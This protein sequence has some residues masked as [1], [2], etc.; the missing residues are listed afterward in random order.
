MSLAGKIA[1][2][3]A[4]Y[5]MSYLFMQGI[6][7]VLALFIRHTLG[8]EQMGVWVG[9]Q[10]LLSYSKYSNLGLG[11]A[12]G[13]EIPFEKGRG[14]L[15]RAERIR[16]SSYTFTL[17]SAAVLSV[18]MVAGAV[19][20]RRRYG[21]L[22]FY[23]LLSLA[24]LS[25][26]QRASTFC[27]SLLRAEKQFS[28]I[29][30]FNV[31]SALVNAGLTVG[32][33]MA[34]GLYGYYAA[35]I[36]SFVFNFY[37]VRCFS[38]VKFGL[39]WEWRELGPLFTMGLGLIASN[40][41]FTFFCSVDK[42]SIGS[43]LGF[44]ELGLYSL[45]IMVSSLVIAFPNNLGIIVFPYL[46]EMHGSSSDQNRLRKLVTYPT[47][48]MA[49]Y[50]PMVIGL[51]WIFGSPLVQ[52][53]L[54]KYAEGIPAMKIG[55][56]A[57]L[58]MILSSN[59]ADALITFKKYLWTLPIQAAIGGLLFIGCVRVI[60]YGAGI[61]EVAWLMT[62]GFLTLYVLYA[63][64]VLREIYSW[65]ETF[66]A[67]LK[68]VVCAG[69]SLAALILFDRLW[70]GTSLGSIALRSIGIFA[71]FLPLIVLGEHEFGTSRIL[72]GLV[73][74]NPIFG[75]MLFYR[76]IRRYW[77]KRGGE[78]YFK[79]QESR[80][81]R[82]A[83][84]RFLAEEISRLGGNT[85]LEVGCGYGKILKSLRE[86]T[87][88][89]LTGIDFSS[90]QLEKARECLA[91]LNDI[92]LVKGDG[93]R[94]PFP[95]NSFDVVFTSNVILHNPPKKADNMRR[96]ILRV[97]KKYVVHKEDT[98]TNFSRYGYD[99]A[100]IYKKMGLKVLRAEK[101]GHAADADITQFTVV[102]K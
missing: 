3:F 67:I 17:V 70:P 5:S 16:N 24:A 6:T 102:E 39:S 31:L 32:L 61:T 71:A 20:F 62:C 11:N 34:F 69:Y 87:C 53:F 9:L 55:L 36:L 37:Y 38:G 68:V 18:V 64:I 90:S 92:T 10:V 97:A 28:F 49:I 91:G 47:F 93:E 43:F 2:E 21:D 4:S 26:F 88:A 101:V 72:A 79:E 59:M 35:M 82:G 14:H 50:V 19:F 85:I 57:T 99:H 80:A 15:E 56:F 83:T 29:N 73:Q 44:K 89:A 94:L 7:I 65:R 48:F 27:I 74:K 81:D 96:E 12:A 54:P 75:R 25:F 95:D 41:L 33:I 45:L 60:S 13:R 86:H 66:V 77:E 46:N 52:L 40:A 30:R 76:D 78:R 8:P 98:D 58:F 51:I 84:S 23:S 22:F 100:E 42:I 63:A 1:G